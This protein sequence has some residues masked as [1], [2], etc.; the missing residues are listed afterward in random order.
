MRRLAML[1]GA[2]AVGLAGCGAQTVT[3]GTFVARGDVVCAAATR[4]IHDLA[5]PRAAPATQ[6]MRFAGY[7]DDYV[8]EMRL[9]LIDLR[10]IGYP[11]GQR[12]RLTADYRHLAT[13]LVV[14]ER[15]P[16]DFDPRIFD[17]TALAL[18]EAGLSAC[19]P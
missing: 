7:V 6:P 1:L 16:L 19:R 18:R 15:D 8:A 13:L 3:R 17:S 10:S 11:T 2:G 4:H 14:A 5:A 12:A 9:E